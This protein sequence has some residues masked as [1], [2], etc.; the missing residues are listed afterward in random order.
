MQPRDSYLVSRAFRSFLFASVMTVAASQMGAFIDGL[1]V[2]WFIS[3]TAMS[4]INIAMP[5]LQLYFSLCLLLGVGGT[6][7]AGKAIGSH[8]RPLASRIFSISTS[9]AVII[10]LLLGAGGLLLFKPLL[11]LLCPDPS[12]IGF[13]GEYLII[14][15]PS[16]AIYML[17]ILLQLFVA[18]DGEPRRVTL[19][20]SVCIAVNL[21][22]DYLFIAIFHWGMTG[23]AAATVISYIP[24]IALLL[25]HFRGA[26]T[27]RYHWPKSFATLPIIMRNGAPSG[28]TA[29]LMSVQIFIC[30]IVAIHYLGTAG[31]ILFAVCM[32][33]LRLSMIILTGTIDSFQPVAAILAGSDDNRGVA[34]VLTKAYTFLGISLALYAG[35]M[36]LFPHWIGSLFSISGAEATEAIGSAIPAFAFNIILQCAVGLLIPVYQVYGNTRQAMIVSIGQPLLPM[37]LFWAMAAAGANA[38]WGFAIGQLLVLVLLLPVVARPAAGRLPFLLIPIRSAGLLCDTSILPTITDAGTRLLEVDSR[39]REAGIAEGLR[40]RIVVSCEEILKN[41]ICHAGSLNR[42]AHSIDLRISLQPDEAIAVIHDA[43]AP[44][45]PVE[46]DPGTGIGL[47]I[48]KRSCDTMKYEYL[49]NQNILTMTWRRTPVAGSPSNP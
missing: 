18:L 23:A 3:D 21:A 41:I 17:M 37:L 29:M 44:F 39:L 43:A 5:V 34:M 7:L 35:V 12:I 22:L 14:T 33:L 28:F 24:A 2:T 48:A 13:A 47:L 1:M 31:V 27:L 11:G 26:D 8:D 6:I 4:A 32:Y 38:W 10:G 15:I 45:N 9:A 20:V 19:A 46:Q 25:T 36:I 49:F 16:A 30:N 40:Y 42:K